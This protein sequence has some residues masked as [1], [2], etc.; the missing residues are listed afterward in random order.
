M[1]SGTIVVGMPEEG[2]YRPIREDALRCG[3]DN[4]LVGRRYTYPA[5]VPHL[6]KKL[7]IPLAIGIIG[8]IVFAGLGAHFHWPWNAEQIALLAASSSVTIL[9]GGWIVYKYRKRKRK[10]EDSDALRIDIED[11]VKARQEK[12]RRIL[13]DP[14]YKHGAAESFYSFDS[15]DCLASLLF[16]ADD[17][18]ELGSGSYGTVTRRTLAEPLYSVSKGTKVV[19]KSMGIKKPLRNN[20]YDHMQILCDHPNIAKVIGVITETRGGKIHIRDKAYVQAYRDAD[21]LNIIVEDE[22]VIGIIME[23]TPEYRSLDKLLLPDSTDLISIS[24]IRNFLRELLSAIKYL[25]EQGFRHSDIKM[26]NI[27]V[28]SEGHVKL[29][30]FGLINPLRNNHPGSLS[31][32]APE[33]FRTHL[34]SSTSDLYSAMKT[35]LLYMLRKDWCLDYPETIPNT[36][37]KEKVSNFLTGGYTTAYRGG[38]IPLPKPISI[39]YKPAEGAAPITAMTGVILSYHLPVDGTDE[40]KDLLFSLMRQLLH[41]EPEQ[42]LTASGWDGLLRHRFFTYIPAAAADAEVA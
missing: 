29:I 8:L 38:S 23:D 13:A 27:L 17:V 1:S 33:I 11:D 18:E 28:D 35:C 32:N 19:V 26:Q 39:T 41:P 6:N 37:L 16:T 2:Y 7:F 30:D 24:F 5:I 31:T 42:R 4:H 25:K 20:T 3:R 34:S 22:V 15:E 10:L 14:K 40:E 9:S 12:A 36:T 21:A